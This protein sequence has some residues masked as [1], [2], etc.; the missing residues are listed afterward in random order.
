MAGCD[1]G[2]TVSGPGFELFLPPGY[3]Q[4][5]GSS[6]RTPP[7]IY[8]VRRDSKSP[9]RGEMQ[10]YIHR[11]PAPYQ[12]IDAASCQA[13]RDGIDAEEAK[14]Q[15]GDELPTMVKS[16][17]NMHRHRDT[18]DPPYIR[19]HL[20]GAAC[21]VDVFA[22]KSVSWTLLSFIVH[23]GILWKVTCRGEGEEMSGE[24]FK[25]LGGLRF[26]P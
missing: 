11:E 17:L 20:F 21:H 13:L 23:G 15:P 9:P 3:K 4:H 8:A 18:V 12:Q 19:E 2:T 16:L 22:T 10:I 6:W 26:T 25:L 5:D 14:P 1:K 7:V 24:C